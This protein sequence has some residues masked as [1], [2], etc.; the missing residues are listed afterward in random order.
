[1]KLAQITGALG[2][3]FALAIAGSNFTYATDINNSQ[4]TAAI[5]RAEAAQKAA[6]EH[7]STA[8][9]GLSKYLAA[10]IAKA[11]NIRKNGGDTATMIQILN[12][13]SE[14]A[15]L[16]ASSASNNTTAQSA[17]PRTA[18]NTPAAPATQTAAPASDTIATAVKVTVVSNPDT[19]KDTAPAAETPAPR[20]LSDA[21]TPVAT[22]AET[23]TSAQETKTPETTDRSDAETDPAKDDDSTVALPNTGEVTSGVTELIIAGIAVV[24]ITIGATV[25]IVKG[26][27]NA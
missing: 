10:Q 2:L 22:T 15:S 18:T 25:I 27:R 7:P 1:M 9:P 20:T 8:Y 23:G 21:G 16:I 6:A 14:A 24:L 3:A 11:E 13:A 12:E 26:K 17:T 4:L 19:T 5:A